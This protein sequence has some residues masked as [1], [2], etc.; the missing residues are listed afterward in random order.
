VDQL[1]SVPC[2]DCGRTFPPRV[3]SFDHRDPDHKVSE[4]G[5]FIRRGDEEGLRTEIAK[6]DIVCLVCHGLRPTSNTM[7]A[8]QKARVSVGVKAIAKEVQNRPEVRAKKSASQTIAM[9]AAYENDPTLRD[10]MSAAQTKSHAEN[11]KRAEDISDWMKSHWADPEQKALH[12]TAIQQMW[13][14]KVASPEFTSDEASALRSERAMKAWETK[15]SKPPVILSPEETA[16]KAARK[17]AAMK[18][19]WETRRAKKSVI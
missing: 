5:E 14:A 6:C 19:S 8:E 1:K 16:A 4:I 13:V 18:S 10:R 15:R 3:M 11:P 7:T 17:T 9:K 2:M 12:V